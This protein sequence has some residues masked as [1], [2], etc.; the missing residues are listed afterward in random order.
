MSEIP[1]T[2]HAI[3]IVGKDEIVWNQAKPVD[4]V[5]PTQMLLKVEACGICFSD[6]KL[7]HAFDGHP[8]KTE[9]TSGLDAEALAQIPSYHPGTQPITPGHEPVARVIA[10]GDAVEHFS[11]G[12]RVL[13]QAD[14]KHIRTKD[15]NA[16]FGYNFDG[17][18]QQYV[19]VD[20]RCVVAPDGEKFLIDVAEGPS[21]AAVGLIEPWATVEGS[22]AFAERNHVRDG[23][24]LLV[25]AEGDADI[26]ALTAVHQPR[27]V[28]R[29]TSAAG[30]E[31]KFDDVVYFGADADTI[32]AL[33]ELVGQRGVLCIVQGGER[34]QRKVMVDVGRIHYDFIRICGTPGTDPVEGYAW[35]PANG[36]LRDGDDVLIVGA[37]GP[38]GTMHTI[39]NAVAE[40]EGLKITAT[41]LS[42]DR[43]AHLRT[44]VDGRAAERG[45]EVR[46]VNTG[47]EEL[48]PGY[49]YIACMVPVPAFVSS[50]VE[51][52]GDDAIVNAF[53]GIPVGNPHEL[54]LQHVIDHRVF[55]F[56]TS[57]SDV[58]DM[59][60]VLEKIEAGIID[61][62]ISLDAITGMA[63]FQDAID[64]VMNR[65]S[66]GKIMVFP[67]LPEL[68][69]LRLNQLEE[70]LPHVAAK[71]RDGI[72]T[73][74]AEAA[75]LGGD[76]Q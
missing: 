9:V 60:T 27:E 20:E 33:L 61:T 70:H 47:N 50:L 22:Y 24:R 54:D 45:V 38:M 37:A 52:A 51:L 21:A 72:W 42:D 75:L 67:Q 19:V 23:G 48:E 8:R 17:A 76:Q 66:G 6:T 16:A 13:V 3:Q 29:A 25:V 55:I 43:L 53:A 11:V 59:R 32:E 73:T 62:H 39:R 63:G 4:P 12:D 14:W 2:Q 36:E 5:G 71:L 15:S 46:Y 64:A 34:I 69:Y 41:D 30:V 44:L 65:T 57:G 26:E 68:P 74:E 10:A 7:L 31:G 58:A 28:V 18:L 40:R 35:I 1:A 56:G 49:T